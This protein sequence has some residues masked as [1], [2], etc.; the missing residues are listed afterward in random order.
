MAAA[1]NILLKV[2]FFLF[3]KENEA[4]QTIHMKNQA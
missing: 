4:W 1:E 3:L 2:F